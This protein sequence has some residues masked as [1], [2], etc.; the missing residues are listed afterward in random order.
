MVIKSI[1]LILFLII[2]LLVNGQQNQKDSLIKIAN[3]HDQDTF[4]VNAL[5]HLADMQALPDSLIKY[6]TQ[7]RTI[8]EK[9]EYKKGEADCFLI[10]SKLGGLSIVYGQ[11]IQYAL[12]ALSIYTD[13]GYCGGMILAH[14]RL[15]ALYRAMGEY[16]NSLSHAFAALNMSQANNTTGEFMF[17]GHAN[18]PLILAEIG[19]TYVLINNLDSALYFTQKAIEKKELFNNSEW[20]FPVYLLATIQT[21]QGN[22]IPA[23]DNYRRALPLAVKNELYRDTLQIFSGMSTLF[24]NMQMTDSAIHYAQMVVTSPNPELETK[25]FLEAIT[26]L[27]DLYKIKG[28]KDSALKYV[29]LSYSLK[30]SIFSREKDKEIQNIAFNEKLK[31]QQL[32]ASQLKFKSKVQLYVLA[33]GIFILFLIAAILWRNNRN[34]QQARERIEKAYAELK[35][36]QQQLIQSEKMASLG[37]LTA[38]IA[39]EIQNP[40][41]FVNNFSDV[42]TELIDEAE[43]E[44][45][46]GNIAE[47]K[48]ILSDVK[49]NEQ[50][51]NHHGKRAD[52]IV[53]GMLQHSRTSSGQ[54]ELTDVNNL[55]EEYLRL[56]C[57]GLRAKDKTFN[58]VPIAI[59]IKTELDASIGKI[60]IVPQDIGCVL[61]NLINNAFYAVNEKAKQRGN[62]YQPTVT[63]TTRSIEPPL[64]G[65]GVQINVIDNGG[66]IPQKILDKIFQPFFTTKPT[67]QGT[68]LGL[69]LAYDIVKAHGGEIKAETKE[70]EG[71]EFTVQLPLN[72]A[73]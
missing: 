9:L 48:N 27:A 4:G 10:L 24:K 22:Y 12:D 66:G 42:N 65:R 18:L 70:G 51:I 30:D 3:E 5:L 45:M 21:M 2:E 19:Q 61:L 53:K 59:G 38:G 44:I 6:V 68:G 49:D 25:N 23:L 71:S 16:S 56:A 46:K 41:N 8:L 72:N 17:W 34:K 40:L 28:N 11:S 63:I 50:K 62:D 15:Q 7:A 26:N 33:G 35:S 14:G 13:I 31:K 20:N 43:R 73:S 37:E 47:A 64:G 29:E 67:G 69:S 39:H 1:I 54:K 36:T 58:A 60:D 32:I 52:S 57:H 55:A